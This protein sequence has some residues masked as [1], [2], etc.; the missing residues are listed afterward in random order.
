M[1]PLPWVEV[2]LNPEITRLTDMISTRKQTKKEKE[3]V[4]KVVILLLSNML[5]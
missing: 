1:N 5:L 3:L 2:R 4:F